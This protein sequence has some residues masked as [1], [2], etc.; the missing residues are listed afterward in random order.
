MKQRNLILALFTLIVAF[1][2]VF[3]VWRLRQAPPRTPAD[4]QQDF[5]LVRMQQVMAKARRGEKIVIGGIGGSI[6]EGYNATNFSKRYLTQVYDWWEAHFPGQVTLINA[7]ISGTGSGLGVHRI[8]DDLLAKNPD[9]VIVEFAVNDLGAPQR[10]QTIEGLI[11][12]TLSQP[13]QPAVL[14]LYFMVKSGASTQ[15]DFAPLAEHYRLPQVSYG[16]RIQQLVGEGK[17]A[18]DDVFGDDVHPN[19]MGHTYAASFITE[20]L[21]TTY[22][23]LPAEDASIS[24]PAGLPSPLFSDVFEHNRCLNYD[25]FQPTMQGNWNKG[26][27]DKIC[28][29]GWVGKDT[30]AELIFPDLEGI[31]FGVGV[32]TQRYRDYG[33]AEIWV[34][35]GPHLKIDSYM[36][37]STG[38]WG[39]PVPVFYL[40]AE[41]LPAGKHT[42]HVRVLDEK[43]PEVSSTEVHS[44]ELMNVFVDGVPV[45]P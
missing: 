41:N 22:D 20:Y 16:D 39:G 44:F 28:G 7:G 37:T 6:T 12:K 32:K 5:G 45:T 21:D 13:N 14:L 2:A 42:L 11:R 36:P 19:D 15:A 30:G 43:N 1:A 35:D 17:I 10:Q 24:I 40:V 34:D 8:E 3:L 9:F 33:M 18:L 25:N 29:G 4:S 38:P 26:R 23:S 27:Y 31:T